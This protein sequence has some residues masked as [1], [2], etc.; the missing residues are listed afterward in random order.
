MSVNKTLVERGD[1]YGRFEDVAA[2]SSSIKH[3]IRSSDGWERLRPY[4]KEALDMIA[5]KVARIVNGD[6]DYIDSWHD[7]AG[8]ASLAEQELKNDN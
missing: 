7:I 1:R 8:Y 4:Q 3:I 2:T 5:N 6:P